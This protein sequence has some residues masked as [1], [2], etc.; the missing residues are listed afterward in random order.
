[1]EQAQ[2]NMSKGTMSKED[3]DALIAKYISQLDKQ[4]IMALDLAKKHLGTSF[5]VQKSNGFKEWL[6]KMC[7]AV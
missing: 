4:Q 6:S 2:V 3:K 7:C 5:N 1:M